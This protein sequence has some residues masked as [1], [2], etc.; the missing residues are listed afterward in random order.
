MREKF[1]FKGR[2]DLVSRLREMVKDLPACE[3]PALRESV[4]KYDWK[5]MI[6][7]YDEKFSEL[8][9]GRDK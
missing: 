5:S 6:S 4:G 1:L 2:V 7:I 8:V 9:E 3:E